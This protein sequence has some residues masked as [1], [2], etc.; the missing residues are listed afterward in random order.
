VLKEELGYTG[1][2][3]QKPGSQNIKRFFLLQ[4]NQIARGRLG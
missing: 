2:L 4:E 1:V 3:Q